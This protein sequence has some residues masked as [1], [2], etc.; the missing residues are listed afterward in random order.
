MSIYSPIPTEPS[1]RH[2]YAV[3]WKSGIKEL[4]SSLTK[5]NS[6]A[7]ELISEISDW[8]HTYQPDEAHGKSLAVFRSKDIFQRVYLEDKIEW[9]AVAAPHFYIR[10]L[11][12]VLEK[13]HVFYILALSQKDTRLLRCTAEGATPVELGKG[14]PTSFDQYLNLAQPDHLLENRS[15]A[16]PSSGNS[17]GV[18]FGTA[19]GSEDKPEHMN[20]F[21][22]QVDNGLKEHLKQHSEPVVLMGV[23]YEMAL[24]RVHS[25]YTNLVEEG[26][27]GAAG[28]L[29][30]GEMV[31]K[32]SEVLD[33]R[34]AKKLDEVLHEYERSGQQLLTNTVADTVLAAHDGRVRVLLISAS[35]QEQTGTIDE[36]THSVKIRK[37]DSPDQEDLLNDAAAQTILHGGQVLVTP[38]E[39]M[40]GQSPLAAILRF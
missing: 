29:K 31:T 28:S 6:P 19:S 21:F 11:L 27:H 12:P 38:Q 17:K 32:A 24:Y 4:E 16:G 33:R 18:L 3:R 2:L 23:E 35:G 10:P 25:T 37:E 20:H 5:H 26:I 22:K 14:V 1:E 15:S 13:D 9:Q 40:P 36:A 39:K 7:L 30:L 8:E 34:R